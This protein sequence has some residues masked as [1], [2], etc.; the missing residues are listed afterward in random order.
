M[1]ADNRARGV[2]KELNTHLKENRSALMLAHFPTTLQSLVPELLK[3]KLPHEPMPNSLTPQAVLQLTASGTPRV[4]FGLVR[5]LRLPELP[6]SE[7]EPETPLAVILVERHFLREHDDCVTQF[8]EGLG[9]RAATVHLALDDELMKLFA[10]QWITDVLK[11]LGMK[12]GETIE[13][14]MVTR[15]IRKAQDH[16]RSH[17]T[18][19]E[20]TA[21]SPLEWLRQNAQA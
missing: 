15:R 13:S 18:A 5:N 20:V 12:D 17:L 21:D 8:A 7:D 6:A 9:N 10:G 11:R 14:G 19:N 3:A 1:D 2:L 16:F 4:L